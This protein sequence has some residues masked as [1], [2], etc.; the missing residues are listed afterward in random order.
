MYKA[1]ISDSVN[2]VGCTSYECATGGLSEH[3]D[4]PLVENTVYL[5]GVDGAYVGTTDAKALLPF[6]LSSPIWD[7]NPEVWSGLSSGWMGTSDCSGWTDP[8]ALGNVG[9][10]NET[11]SRFFDRYLQFCNRTN[12]LMYCAEQLPPGKIIFTTNA[13]P[14]GDLGGVAGADAACQAEAPTPGTFKALIVDGSSRVACTTSDCANGPSEHVDWPLAAQTLYYRI[15]ST[16]IGSTDANGLFL[17]PLDASPA[18]RSVEVWT[19]LNTDWT[20]GETCAAWTDST[21]Y[22]V[23]G[24]SDA[25]DDASI[26]V[27]QQFCDRSNVSLYCVQQ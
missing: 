18:R 11:D 4:W 7:T 17:F 22:G 23:N 14:S 20:T 13:Q 9:L 25:A 2:R 10:G 6:P 16:V 24:L 1:L 21:A 19:G 12:V 26:Y 15:D 3:V 5:R 8:N 27:Y